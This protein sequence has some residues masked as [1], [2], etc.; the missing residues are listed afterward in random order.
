MKNYSQN[1]PYIFSLI[2]FFSAVLFAILV[3]L[4]TTPFSDQREIGAIIEGFGYILVSLPFLFLLLSFGWLKEAG[5][6][7]P[8]E[9]KVWIWVALVIPIAVCPLLLI[10]KE[11][12]FDFP[13]MLLMLGI[14]VSTFGDCFYQE[15]IYRGVI[16]TTFCQKWLGLP[17]GVFKAVIVTALYFGFSHLVNMAS[18]ANPILTIT[19]TIYS[20]G[21]GVFFGALLVYSKSIWPAIAAH[22]LINCVSGLIATDKTVEANNLYI[23]LVLAAPILPIGAGALLLLWRAIQDHARNG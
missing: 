15:T 14:I 6:Q 17:K 3:Y 2:I 23:S 18:G 11:R 9:K 16:Q 8:K 7:P 1:H 4:P 13:D 21:L 22:W 19:L 12:T 10:Y 5:F 20:I